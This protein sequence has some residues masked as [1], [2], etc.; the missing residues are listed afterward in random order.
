MICSFWLPC[1]RLG[2]HPGLQWWKAPCRQTPLPVLLPSL[3]EGIAVQIPRAAFFLQHGGSWSY[4]D[5]EAHFR[6]KY[7]SNS[8]NTLLFLWGSDTKIKAELNPP[9]LISAQVSWLLPEL[10]KQDSEGKEQ[11]KTSLKVKQG[12]F[13]EQ[14]LASLALELLL[15]CLLLTP[16]RMSETGF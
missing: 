11:P 16:G 15:L 8:F 4:L 13:E 7:H 10:L 2:V 5:D 3:A 1:P 6:I 14:G 12:D 9:L